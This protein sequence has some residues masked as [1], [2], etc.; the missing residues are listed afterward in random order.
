MK[1]QRF[2]LS[3]VEE[4]SPYISFTDLLVG[5]I[6]IFLLLI[7]LLF[8]EVREEKNEGFF[9]V[10]LPTVSD[11]EAL[12][13]ILGTVAENVNKQGSQV[14][15]NPEGNALVLAS[16]IN[17]ATNQRELSISGQATVSQIAQALTQL[18][19]CHASGMVIPVNYNCDEAAPKIDTI[20]IE[21]HTDRQPRAGTQNDLEINWEISMERAQNVFS[22]LMNSSP[23]LYDL[24]SYGS[25]ENRLFGVVGYAYTRP[26][27][28]PS[29]SRNEPRD[30]RVEIR[31][32]LSD[33]E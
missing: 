11:Q 33:N 4:E 14:T 31:F 15:V 5:L 26:A 2:T 13:Q 30:R 25:S 10:P 27:V 3:N 6:F 24:R 1:H 22:A 32:I 7:V 12:A 17:F 8:L 23:V 29:V 20:L 9:D 18:L 19:P 16:D 21:G 28:V